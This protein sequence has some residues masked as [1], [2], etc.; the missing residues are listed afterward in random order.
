MRSEGPAGTTPHGRVLAWSD[1]FLTGKRRNVQFI[2]LMYK[3]SDH[4]LPTL[5]CVHVGQTGALL[6][7]AF[8][9]IPRVNRIDIKTIRPSFVST[10]F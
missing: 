2:L 4:R 6:R 9:S 1:Q 8:K 10:Y 7:M 5:I 3:Q